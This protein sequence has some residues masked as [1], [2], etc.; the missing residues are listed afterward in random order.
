MHD[1]SDIYFVGNFHCGYFEDSFVPF[2][3]NLS[4]K[5]V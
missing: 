3:S 1:V 5:L 2:D 4:D